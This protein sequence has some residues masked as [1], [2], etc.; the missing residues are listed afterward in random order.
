[1]RIAWLKSDDDGG[2]GDGDDND[3]DSD[4]GGDR[5]DVDDVTMRVLPITSSQNAQEVDRSLN[6]S[7][8]VG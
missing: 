7:K 5:D 1:M 4:D 3:N 6:F 8:E 2:G